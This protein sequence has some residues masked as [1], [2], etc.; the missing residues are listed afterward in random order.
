MKLKRD[1]MLVKAERNGSDL[2]V[3]K[4]GGND[5]RVYLWY[6]NYC[7][8]PTVILADDI[9][10]AYEAAVDNETPI[11]ETELWEAYGLDEPGDIP[12]GSELTEGYEYQ[13]NATGTG[14][15][16]V[17]HTCGLQEYDRHSG[18][19]LTVRRD[20]VFVLGMGQPGC[21]YDWGPE[22]YSSR[23]QA[24]ASLREYLVQEGLSQAT[25]RRIC[26]EVDSDGWA[27]LDRRLCRLGFYPRIELGEDSR[28]DNDPADFYEYQSNV[29]N[30]GIVRVA[31]SGA[32]AVL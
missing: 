20:V 2:T 11:E 7:S 26:R 6:A 10:D 18:V 3:L 8:N 32:S 16:S 17:D 5:E 21:L 12:E 24:L 4:A 30:A 14:I 31:P 28:E 15:V 25:A 1:T 22:R 19:K 23:H 13:P 27:Q 9:S 29:P